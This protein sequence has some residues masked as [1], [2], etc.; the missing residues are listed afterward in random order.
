MHA[1]RCGQEEQYKKSCEL[2]SVTS[3]P[4]GT[5]GGTPGVIPGGLQEH[6]ALMI[7]SVVGVAYGFTFFASDALHEQ[8]CGTF[9]FIHTIPPSLCV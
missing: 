7:L 9:I 4:G 2:S 3:S 1:G 8:I 5:P 6:G